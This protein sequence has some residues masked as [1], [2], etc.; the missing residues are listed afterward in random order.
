MALIYGAL[1]LN[2]VCTLYETEYL[3]SRNLAPLTRLAYLRDLNELTGFLEE[4]CQI[5]RVDH[6]ERRHLEGFLGQLDRQGLSGNYRRRKVAIRSLF[7]FLEDRGLIPASP[8]RKLLPPERGRHQSRYLTELEYKRLP[9]A[10]RHE[11]RTP[12]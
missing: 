9:E 2:Y 7:A 10:V 3:A 4:H 1:T 5:S 11:P 8:A 12:R 6:V